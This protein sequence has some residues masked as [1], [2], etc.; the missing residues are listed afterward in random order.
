M[1]E[2]VL[3]RSKNSSGKVFM[4][5]GATLAI[6][7][8]VVFNLFFWDMRLGPD[9]F[10]PILVLLEI[11]VVFLPLTFIIVSFCKGMQKSEL[12][13]TKMRIFGRAAFG[14]DFEISPDSVSAISRSSLKGLKVTASSRVI[15]FKLLSNADEVYSAISSLLV[16]QR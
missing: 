12:V 4:N 15:K 6:T 8:A 10:S 1:I 2:E 13:V 7:I 5:I 16:E 9:V 14:K 3:V 11:N